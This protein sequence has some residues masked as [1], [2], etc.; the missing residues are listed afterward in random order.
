MQSLGAVKKVFIMR[1]SN[2][3]LGAT[4]SR[5]TAI[6]SRGR[7]PAPENTSPPGSL[8]QLPKFGFR[9]HYD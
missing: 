4:Q 8:W 2:D 3:R 1:R 9:K 6:F 7:W 5:E